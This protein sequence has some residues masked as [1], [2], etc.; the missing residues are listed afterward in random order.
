MAT[1][2]VN[3]AIINTASDGPAKIT[4]SS[5]NGTGTLKIEPSNGICSSLTPGVWLDIQGADGRL[6]VYTNTGN[7]YEY[8][9]TIP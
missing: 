7:G 8:K 3:A 2:S 4:I 6:V 5:K 9:H 1:G